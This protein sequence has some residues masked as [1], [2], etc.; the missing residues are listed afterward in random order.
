[1]ILRRFSAL[2]VL[3]AVATPVAASG[4]SFNCARATGPDERAICRSPALSAQDRQLARLYRDVQHCTAMGGRGANIDDQ[5]DWLKAR[6]RCGKDRACLVG[7]YRVRIRQ[8]A[9]MAAHARQYLKA[10]DC[11]RPL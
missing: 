10:G 8:F 7:L 9:P 3:A 2:V 1:M 11:P 6:A 5:L 4:P